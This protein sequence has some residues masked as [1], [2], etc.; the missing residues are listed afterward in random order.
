MSEFNA[1]LTRDQIATQL[2]RLRSVWNESPGADEILI[3]ASL[4][5]AAA[6]GLRDEC[7]KEF[8]KDCGWREVWG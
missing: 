1:H 2:E 4:T 7:L 5:F 6:L 8:M 3:D